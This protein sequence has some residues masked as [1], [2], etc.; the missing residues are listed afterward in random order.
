MR[1]AILD[2]QAQ[3]LRNVQKAVERVGGVADIVSSPHA[4]SDYDALILP[5]VGAFG[6]AMARL[7]DTDF[8]DAIRRHALEE[9]KPVLGICLGM[10]LMASVGTE[11]GGRTG[12]GL[13]PM[14]VRRFEGPGFNQRLPHIGWSSVDAVPSSHLF[15]GVP[16]SADFYFVH[17]Y[18]VDCTD[19]SVVS[20]YCDYG[21]RFAAAVERG[22]LFGAQ[23]HPEKSQRYGLQVLKNFVD[24]CV[25][26]EVAC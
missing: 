14:T 22:N 20:A 2:Y 1:I 16:R 18:H 26:S 19:T 4:L 25:G 7:T 17:S 10:Q 3:N 11:G 24:C 21:Y 13:L 15:K 9:E 5:G 6:H 23:F 8:P 12:L